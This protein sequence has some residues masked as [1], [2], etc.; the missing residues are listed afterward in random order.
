[1][2]NDRFSEP[3]RLDYWGPAHDWFIH[4]RARLDAEPTVFH[5]VHDTG[6][7]VVYRIE[8]AALDTLK[9]GLTPRP[10]L[11]VW[12]PKQGP[13]PRYVAPGMPQLLSL[14]MAAKRGRPGERIPVVIE[15]RTRET[16]PVGAYSVSVR[17]DHATLPGFSPP[18]WC[19]KPARKL[20]EKLRHERFRFRD[21]HLPVG[22]D[23]GVDLWRPTEVVRD[24]FVVAVP[25]DVAPG[26]YQVQVL[27]VRGP[28]YANYRLSDYFLDHDYYSGV[29]AGLF[30]VLPAEA[31]P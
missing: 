8:P 24:S 23:Y 31:R 1:M 28:H 13:A 30:R 12:D 7:F 15:W 19:G 16:L 17:F 20:L 4:A 5:R 10:Y 26:E 3:P 2:L 18:A 21:D 22:G 14:R 11:R 9:G 27:M 6:D 25:E 29:P